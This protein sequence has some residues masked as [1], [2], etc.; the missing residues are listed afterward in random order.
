MRWS[1]VLILPQP[2]E[3]TPQ[4]TS[5]TFDFSYNK[6]FILLFS[7]LTPAGIPPT[8][9]LFGTTVPNFGTE[10]D[11]IAAKELMEGEGVTE[12]CT[13]ESDDCRKRKD[14]TFL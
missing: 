3:N 8:K 4:S 10:W 6:A 7:L 14:V 9:I 13:D 5:R 1:S 2:S 12:A 11:C